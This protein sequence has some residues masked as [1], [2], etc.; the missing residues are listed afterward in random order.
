MENSDDMIGYP[1]RR[2]PKAISQKTIKAKAVHLFIELPKVFEANIV[3][4]RYR[5]KLSFVKINFI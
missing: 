4:V 3:Y 2:F 5:A 1:T